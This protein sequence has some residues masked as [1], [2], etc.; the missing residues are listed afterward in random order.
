M[1]GRKGLKEWEE[2]T[3]KE[4]RFVNEYMRNG[5]NATKAYQDAG[6]WCG[7]SYG[8]IKVSAFK[9]RHR[10]HIESEIASRMDEL[11]MSEKEA[12]I[13]QSEVARFD[14][15]ELLIAEEVKCPECGCIVHDAKEWRVDLELAKK[16]GVSN[17][18]KKV[19][20]DKNG[21]L[22]VEFRDVDAAQKTL[23]QAH[24][25][26]RS[27]KQEAVADGMIALL[28][29]ARANVQKTITAHD[30]E[31]EIETPAQLEA[32]EPTRVQR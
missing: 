8:A 7:P 14:I 32:N 30:A 20:Y 6:Y 2:F 16:L 21:R 19:S 1:P 10:P 4:Q 25:T 12:L 17:R 22:V 13:Q 9:L 23:L 24:G 3:E 29:A 26:F 31:F 18:I 5:H 27:K 28:N 15:G 11:L